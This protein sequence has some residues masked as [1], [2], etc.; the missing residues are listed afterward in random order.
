M[1]YSENYEFSL[2]YKADN[3]PADI[4]LLS[5]N[6]KLIDEILKK[7]EGFLGNNV[8]VFEKN[9]VTLETL[10][11]EIP[12]GASVCFVDT[13]KFVNGVYEIGVLKS[14]N[15]GDENQ[16]YQI[17][18]IWYGLDRPMQRKSYKQIGSTSTT[19]IWEDWFEYAAVSDI[20]QEVDSALQQAKESGEFDGADGYTPQKGVDYWTEEDKAE[21][22]AQVKAVCVAKNQGASNVGKILVVGTD[23]NLTLTDMPEGGGT[24]GDVTGVLDESNNILLSGNLADGTYTLKYENADGTYTEIGTLE[25]GAIPEPEPVKTNFIE[26]NTDNKTDWSIWCNDARVGSDGAYRS[27]TTQDATNYISVQNGDVIYINQGR[28][29]NGQIIGLYNSSKGKVSTGTTTDLTS[30]GHISDATS[31]NANTLDA[32]FTIT[33]ASVNFIRFTLNRKDYP[34]LTDDQIVVNIKRNGE[35]L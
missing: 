28:M 23:G 3:D 26:Y 29:I 24:S 33:N 14:Y 34:L 16:L 30:N 31:I 8:N 2:P 4:D 6:F 22:T 13:G 10:P 5:E 11:S 20:E 27:S 7:H 32:Q 19:H 35:W 21:M 9:E 17:T 18:Q 1:K 12:L 15:S 25:V